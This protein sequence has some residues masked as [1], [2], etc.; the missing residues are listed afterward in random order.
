MD[1]ADRIKAFGL[2]PLDTSQYFHSTSRNL[3]QKSFVF[4][5]LLSLFQPKLIQIQSA[6]LVGLRLIELIISALMKSSFDGGIVGEADVFL[7]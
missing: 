5:L 1:A 2:F 6:F 4:R 7:A 3:S